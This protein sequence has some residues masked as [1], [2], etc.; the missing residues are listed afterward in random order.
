MS[1]NPLVPLETLSQVKNELYARIATLAPDIPLDSGAA[2]EALAWSLL[3]ERWPD[4]LPGS[5]IDREGAFYNQYFWSKRFAVLK[6]QQDGYDAG[7][8]QQVFQLLETIDFDADWA[9]IERL[10][11]DAA[12]TQLQPPKGHP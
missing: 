10:N 11:S 3:F 8:E 6:Q 7:L 1:K 5:P 2:G 4:L 12:N 9:L